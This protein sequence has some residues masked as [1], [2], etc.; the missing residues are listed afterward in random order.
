MKQTWKRWV[1]KRG[2]ESNCCERSKSSLVRPPSRLPLRVMLSQSQLLSLMVLQHNLK[3]KPP[4]H[5]R[6][7]RPRREM[8][9][10]RTRWTQ[11]RARPERRLKRSL[12]Q[13]QPLRP[14]RKRPRQM[15]VPTMR[16]S[17]RKS[18]HKRTRPSK[19]RPRRS[20]PKTRHRP[21][22]PIHQLRPRL[23]KSRS[24]LPLRAMLML[25]PNGNKDRR[26]QLQRRRPRQ[27]SKLL[28]PTSRPLRVRLR[29]RCKHRDH[30]Q[31]H[32]TQTS[33]PR[34]RR[35]WR[36]RLSLRAMLLL[37]RKPSSCESPS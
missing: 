9:K 4:K 23:L 15:H 12:R 6:S 7:R 18:K 26:P 16:E 24:H 13:K 25:Q 32:P 14:K 21:P 33:H 27:T 1:S 28:G 30:T 2:H 37:L 35:E 17:K 8:Q 3:V 31:T 22:R 29:P 19:P 10:Q 11:M 34:P 36:S 20:K 5:K